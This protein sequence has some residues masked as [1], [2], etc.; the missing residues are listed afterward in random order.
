MQDPALELYR[1][2]AEVPPRLAKELAPFQMCPIPAFS[3]HVTAMDGINQANVDQLVQPARGEAEKFLAGLPDSAYAPVPEWFPS[4]VVS[5]EQPWTLRLR[6]QRL[7]IRTHSADLVALLEPADAESEQW[8]ALIRAERIERE[9]PMVDRGKTPNLADWTPHLTLGYFFESELAAS[10]R[11][12]LEPWNKA[13]SE[14]AAGRLFRSSSISLFSFVDMKT[15]FRHPLP[16]MIVHKKTI[17]RKLS[18]AT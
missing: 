7:D 12:Y 17:D 2:L 16:A 13:A 6:F 10:A 4:P 11:P 15:F 18:I 8:M 1:A 14:L 9:Q 5:L 3:Y